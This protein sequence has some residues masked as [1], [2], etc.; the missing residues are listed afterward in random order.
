[1]GE[2]AGSG[3]PIAYL[4]GM[5][6]VSIAT[7][8]LAFTVLPAAVLAED[9]GDA[10]PRGQL[11]QGL[12]LLEEGTRLLMQA[13]IAELGPAWAELEEMIDNL[14]AYY[15]PEVMPNGDII[16]RRKSPLAPDDSP[17]LEL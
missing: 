9:H 15:P 12:S 17:D 3:R 14:N 1:M 6:R 13:I 10:Q 5:L 2:K 11:E 7:A 16:I 4:L 8:V